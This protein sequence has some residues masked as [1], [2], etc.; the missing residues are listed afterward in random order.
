MS[1]NSHATYGV[2]GNNDLDRHVLASLNSSTWSGRT[3]KLG[4]GNCKERG[5]DNEELH[6]VGL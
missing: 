4:L 2:N 5:E 3:E 6:V 1:R